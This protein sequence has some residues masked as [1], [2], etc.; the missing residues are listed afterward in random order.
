MI[1]EKKY[2]LW[3]CECGR[4]V[5]EQDP[6]T[7]TLSDGDKPITPQY[8]RICRV[9]AQ[10]IIWTSEQSKYIDRYI[11]RWTK[12]TFINE[13]LTF[14]LLVFNTMSLSPSRCNTIY[15]I[16]SFFSLSPSLHVSALLGH[17]QV[18]IT[19]LNCHTV[20]CIVFLTHAMIV[21]IKDF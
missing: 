5:P 2:K 4:I 10:R 12:F 14:Q 19:M 6:I 7:F 8:L 21:Y 18:L 1:L 17:P 16:L 20:H 3:G 15:I 11:E 13:W 9:S